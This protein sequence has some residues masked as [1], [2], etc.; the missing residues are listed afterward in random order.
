MSSTDKEIKKYWSKLVIMQLLKTI[1]NEKEPVGK[2]VRQS[3]SKT[4]YV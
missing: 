2:K 1:K 4:L 3:F